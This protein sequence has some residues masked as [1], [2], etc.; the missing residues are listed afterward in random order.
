MACSG[1]RLRGYGCGVGVWL[2]CLLGRALLVRGLGV[3]VQGLLV[4]LSCGGCWF[5]RWVS[6][7]CLG[8]DWLRSIILVL[9]AR[10][11]GVVYSGFLWLLVVWY[12]LVLLVCVC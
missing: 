1:L 8:L 3:Y 9:L 10:L 7:L 4:W 11:L 2:T 6:V 5:S 12:V